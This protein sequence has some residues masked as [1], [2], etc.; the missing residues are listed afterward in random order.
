MVEDV[1]QEREQ[2]VAVALDRVERVER[3]SRG[4]EARGLVEQLLAKPRIAVIGVRISWLTLA[5]NSLFT[6]VVC[7]AWSIASRSA[8]F[9]SSSTSARFCSARS[10]RRSDAS[11]AITTSMCR[12]R[13]SSWREPRLAEVAA[14]ALHELQLDLA[15]ARPPRRGR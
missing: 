1:V 8:E 14:V 6:R 13:R 2:V 15:R 5:R 10:F 4:R 12:A 3:V 9:A 7:S 11:R